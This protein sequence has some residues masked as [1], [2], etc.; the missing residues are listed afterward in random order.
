MLTRLMPGGLG[1]LSRRNFWRPNLVADLLELSRPPYDWHCGFCFRSS[2]RQA[3]HSRGKRHSSRSGAFG[4]QSLGP[5]LAH[6]RL[7]RLSQLR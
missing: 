7:P 6:R 5:L 4:L 3:W 2:N 1:L